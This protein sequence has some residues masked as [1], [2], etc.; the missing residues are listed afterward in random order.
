MRLDRGHPSRARPSRPTVSAAIGDATIVDESWAL[1]V[2]LAEAFRDAVTDPLTVTAASSDDT[3]AT[4]SLAADYSTLIVNAQAR[5]TA[6]ITV[7]ADYGPAGAIEVAFTVTVKAAPVASQTIGDISGLETDDTHYVSLAGVFR[8]ADGDALTIS[9]ASSDEGKAAASVTADGSKVAVAGVAAGE[10]TVTV[11]ARDTDGNRVS[12][13][14][15]VSVV[16]AVEAKH[17]EPVGSLRCIARANQVAFA[18]TAPQWS[19]GEVY[20]YDYSLSL[21]DG[22]REQVRLRGTTVVNKRGAYPVGKDATIV[23]KVV[24]ELPDRNRQVSAAAALTCRFGD[25]YLGPRPRPDRRQAAPLRGGSFRHQLREARYFQ[26][27]RRG[28][29]KSG[30]PVWVEDGDAPGHPPNWAEA[31]VYHFMTGPAVKVTVRDND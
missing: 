26:Q 30:I 2:S 9:A 18:W 28:Y 14:F 24:Y 22:R 7:T 12:A 31:P 21:P 8:D 1:E 25:A 3:V 19:G 27:Q 11:T 16:A 6:V 15:D 17:G 13:A 4:V 29:L 5:G 20:A 10:V 23:L